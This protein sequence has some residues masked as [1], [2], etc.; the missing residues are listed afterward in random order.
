M[1]GGSRFTSA[2]MDRP[3]AIAE[4]YMADPSGKKLHDTYLLAWLR[5]LKTTYYLRSWEQH[6]PRNQPEPAVS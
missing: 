1:V 6:R 5:G 3:G 4:S 2:K